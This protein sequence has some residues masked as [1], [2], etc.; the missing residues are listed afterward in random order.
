MKRFVAAFLAVILIA[1]TGVVAFA[2]DDTKLVFE[3]SYD[4]DTNRVVVD[5]YVE[6][7][8]ELVAADL[9]LGFDP[10]IYEYVDSEDNRTISDMMII[11]GLSVASSGLACV[12]AIFTEKCEDS[13]LT[14]GRLHF[15]SF[16]F[17]PLTED[18]DI[19]DFCLWAYSY[20]TDGGSDV[21]KSISATGN[22]AL[23]EGKTAA[24]TV[25]SSDIDT[26]SVSNSLNGKWY[27]YVIAVVLGVAIVAGVAVIAV[28]NGEKEESE[29]ESSQDEK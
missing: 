8:G 16:T 15:V 24:V 4:A 11:S 6:N 27:V 10:D 23:K 3:S 9:R 26:S 1:I 22:K 18:Y 29:Q 20:E 28:K 12:S 7:P 25:A 14:D 19:N 21:S 13:Y 17:S 2:T 5:V